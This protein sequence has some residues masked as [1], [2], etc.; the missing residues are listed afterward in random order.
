M[1]TALS[2]HCAAG[3]PLLA[4]C[5][6][7]MALAQ[8]IDH[9]P[10]L[11]LLPGKITMQPRLQGL[12]VQQVTLPEGAI[13]GHTFHY[14]SFDTPLAALCHAT[15]SSG[16]IGEAVYRERQLTASYLHFYFPSNPVVTAKLFLG[17]TA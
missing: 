13:N 14:S 6:G 1:Q 17:E 15:T 16:K 9:S 8:S 7:M 2:E 3:K 4:E 5:G 12:G 11:G 10:A